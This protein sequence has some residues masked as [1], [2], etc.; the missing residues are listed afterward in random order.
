[1]RRGIIMAWLC[2][3][4]CTTPLV[5]QKSLSP[6]EAPAGPPTS[7][8][9]TVPPI[10]PPQTA[11]E[12][13]GTAVGPGEASPGPPP[14]WETVW[15]LAGIDFIPD[16]AR[17]AP[18]GQEYHPNFYIDLDI[19]FW[20]CRSQGFYLYTED[21]LWGEKGEYGVTNGNDGFLGTSKR[22]FDFSGGLAWN[23][24][25]AWEARAFGYSDNNLNR[26]TN[27]LAPYGFTD[28]FGIENRYYLS[29]EYQKL[30]QPGF[31]VAKAS[32][33]SVGYYPSKV[34]VGNDGQV[35]QP[36]LMLR[37]YL[38]QNLWDWPAYVFGDITYIGE[39]SSQP[40]LL[41]ID[42]GIA[43]RPFS[44]FQQCEFR[45]GLDSIA[46][47]QLHNSDSSFYASIRF[48]F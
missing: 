13:T 1:M 21:K 23:Y 26:G 47:L 48:I 30:G 16:G 35:F 7:Q 22:E 39:S 9:L 45:L 4:V 18:N 43:A 25:G 31:D 17:I 3:L 20:I 5:A 34:M 32:F 41:L 37:A 24:A 38:T 40:K 29:A 42:T 15:G 28:G 46:D 11:A 36:G 12:A 44:S 19:N 14:A 10:G 33:L 8:L 2:G 27:L 6:G